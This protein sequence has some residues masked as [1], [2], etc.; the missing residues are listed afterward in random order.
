MFEA[1]YERKKLK[2]RKL[3]IVLAVFLIAACGSDDKKKDRNIDEERL[4]PEYAENVIGSWRTSGCE[5][6]SI[7]E[8]VVSPYTYGYIIYHFDDD[9]LLKMQTIS[10]AESDC[11]DSANESPISS[12]T[13]EYSLDGEPVSN[14]VENLMPIS[15][16]IDHTEHPISFDTYYTILD[17]NLLCTSRSIDLSIEGSRIGDAGDEINYNQCLEKI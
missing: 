2:Y 10:Y 1:L 12:T 11:S 8:D 6:F 4:V 9:G 15:I 16:N 3:A 14:V 17:G 5:E 7:P 13:T